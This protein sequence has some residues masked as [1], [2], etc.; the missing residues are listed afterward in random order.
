MSQHGFIQLLCDANITIERTVAHDNELMELAIMTN[1]R[2]TIHR[3]CISETVQLTKSPHIL[4][5]AKFFLTLVP[6]YLFS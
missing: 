4:G 1:K 5:H 3:Q 2:N 6:K